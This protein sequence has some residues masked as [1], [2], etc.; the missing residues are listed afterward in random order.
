MDDYECCPFCYHH[1]KWRYGW[2]V[3]YHYSIITKRPYRL[4]A[5]DTLE[6]FTG[7]VVTAYQLIVMLRG[8]YIVAYII[9]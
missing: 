7:Y 9:R 4:Y 5:W 1:L 6:E 3:N 8:M 2:S